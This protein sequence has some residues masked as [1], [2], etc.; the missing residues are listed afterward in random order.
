[1]EAFFNSHGCRIETIN[2]EEVKEPQHELVEDLIAIVTSF[3]RRI[4]GARSH[5]K[6]RIV[7]VVEHAVRDC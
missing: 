5:K 6:R 7:E 2:A 3:A 1:M 4:Y